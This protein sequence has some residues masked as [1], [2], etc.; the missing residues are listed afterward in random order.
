MDFMAA[1]GTCS[2]KGVVEACEAFASSGQRQWLKVAG[3]A[4]AQAGADS[5]AELR[6]LAESFLKAA[7]FF[8]RRSSMRL[9]LCDVHQR[10]PSWPSSDPLLATPAC[11]WLGVQ[12]GRVQGKGK[13]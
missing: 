2:A 8:A 12:D 6:A 10:G 7:R 11:A 9:W 1:T 5:L 4:K 13:S 3:E